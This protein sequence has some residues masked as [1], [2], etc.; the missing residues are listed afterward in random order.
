[1]TLTDLLAYAL[2]EQSKVV[3]SSLAEQ[4]VLTRREGEIAEL[5]AQGLSNREIAS[6]LVIAQRI[7]EGHVEHILAKFGFTSRV[8]I[9][10]WVAGQ[11]AHEQ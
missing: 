2:G 5:V 4:A 9:A 10:A 6:R 7:V 11:Q 3:S 8:Q 1:M